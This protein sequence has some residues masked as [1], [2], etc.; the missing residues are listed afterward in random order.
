LSVGI[1]AVVTD[2]T[3]ITSVVGAA[4]DATV[5]PTARRIDGNAK[6]RRRMG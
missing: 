4:A 3:V 2:L 6:R 5:A 1:E